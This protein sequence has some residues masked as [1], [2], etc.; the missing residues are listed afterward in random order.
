[1]QGFTGCFIRPHHRLPRNLR[2]LRSAQELVPDLLLA[3]PL[4]VP[5]CSKPCSEPC[6]GRDSPAHRLGLHA[7]GP[8]RGPQSYA[9]KRM[10][11]AP[12]PHQA[13]A[14]GGQTLRT[15]AIMGRRVSPSFQALQN[16]PTSPQ[17]AASSG[18]PGVGTG[19]GPPSAS[20]AAGIACSAVGLVCG[21]VAP[22]Y[23]LETPLKGLPKLPGPRNTTV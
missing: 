18:A 5:G 14:P 12:S 13:V 20:A 21:A 10:M 16:Q 11:S 6:P 1:M 22:A 4:Q 17:P 19:V 2:L 23:L 7:W 9:W 3:S 8:G 15:L